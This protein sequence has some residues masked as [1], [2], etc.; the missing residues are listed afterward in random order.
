MGKRTMSLQDA[1]DLVPDD[2]PDGAFWAMAHDI[3]GAEYGEAWGELTARPTHRSCLPPAEK[4]LPCPACDRKF[5]S[6]DARR[7][8]TEAAHPVG[9]PE[10]LKCPVCRK[11][12]SMWASMEQHMA[13]C[14]KRKANS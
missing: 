12:F 11:K 14:H 2:L 4:N 8:H 10:N 3:A 1:C 5:S 13:A 7:Q 9:P 6:E